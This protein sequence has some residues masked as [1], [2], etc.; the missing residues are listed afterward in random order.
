MQGAAVKGGRAAHRKDALGLKDQ[1]VD[2]R[3]AA[4]AEIFKGDYEPLDYGPDGQA[5]PVY[6]HPLLHFVEDYHR[7]Q[8]AKKL[9]EEEARRRLGNGST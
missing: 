8:E 4:A 9:R 3:P 7:E 6:D 2:G 5:E 1:T